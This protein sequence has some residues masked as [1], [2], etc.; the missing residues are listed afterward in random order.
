[1]TVEARFVEQSDYTQ[2]MAHL[3]AGEWRAAIGCLEK[4]LAHD[5]SNQEAQL[6]IADAK[7]K[8]GLDAGAHGRAKGRA[9]RRIAILA[10]SGLV[11]LGVVLLTFRFGPVLQH[12]LASFLA[13]GREEQRLAELESGAQALLQ[14][15]DLDGAEAGYRELLTAAP[16]NQAAQQGLEQIDRTREI[17]D[18]YQRAVAL[19]EGG[20]LATALQLFAEVQ[21]RQSPYLDVGLRVADIQRQQ[22]LEELFASAEADDRAGNPSQALLKYQELQTLDVTFQRERVLQRLF[23]LHVQLG[24]GL[25]E[26]DPPTA[27]AV[28]QALDHF[29]AALT[30]EPRDPAATLERRLAWAFLDA[31]VPYAAGL[32]EG[33]I[34]QLQALLDQRPG[35]LRGLVAGMIQY[36]AH[37][38]GGDQA[39]AAGDC[40]A[41]YLQYQAAAALPVGDTTAARAGL[42][43][44]ESCLAPTPTLPPTSTPQ[45][46]LVTPAPTV[47]AKRQPAATRVKT[48]TPSPST[49]PA[50]PF[51]G[52][53]VDGGS[54]CDGFALVTGFVTHA[55]KTPYPGVAVGVWSDV[56]YGEVATTEASGKFDLLLSGKPVGKYY[57][58]VVKPGT[59]AQVAGLTAV[60]TCQRRSNVLEAT[61]TAKCSGAGANQVSKVSF[62]GP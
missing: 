20:D 61:L 8:S 39:W 31:Q 19:Q 17:Q 16:A 10:P 26:Q 27:A 12:S 32:W 23:A 35:Y 2:G 50:P 9:V 60:R 18:L 36:A 54:R 48:A 30:L 40:D 15:G 47:T 49:T 58:A 59:C 41:A 44:A 22:K 11:V 33:A 29:E 38:L 4:Y 6:A 52:K 43:R 7:L 42:S 55:G 34:S 51:I 53:F 24:L 37:A 3:Q 5:P 25:L 28:P 62:E 45:P 46:P 56:W 14:A 21:A 13:Q 1:M 57:V